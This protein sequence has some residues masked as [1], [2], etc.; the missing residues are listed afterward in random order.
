MI[1]SFVMYIDKKRCMETFILLIQI[2]AHMQQKTT[3]SIVPK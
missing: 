3:E 1:Y 2:G